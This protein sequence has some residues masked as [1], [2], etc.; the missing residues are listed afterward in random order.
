M[1]QVLD[2]IDIADEFG[3]DPDIAEVDAVVRARMQDALDELARERRSRCWAER[4]T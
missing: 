3:D 1:T 2:P 4:V